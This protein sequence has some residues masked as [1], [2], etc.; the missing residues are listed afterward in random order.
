MPMIPPERVDEAIRALL[1]GAVV[2]IPT[3]TVYGLAASLDHPAAVLRLAELKGRAPEQP[4]AV[5]ID[6]AEAVA[7]RLAERSALDRVERL[8]PGA[9]TAVVRV[10]DGDDWPPLVLGAAGN[11]SKT[12]G[13][14]VPDDD[15]ARSV[16]RGCGGALAVTSANRHDDRP[17]SSA[18]GVAAIFGDELLILDGGSRDGGVASTVVDLTTDPPTVLREGAVSVGE[19]GL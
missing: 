10:R 17:A 19:L 6:S 14:R 13:L 5:L 15:L 9:L 2:A 7:S 1:D 11:G 18:Q 12:L 8:W 16:I 3:D 4:I